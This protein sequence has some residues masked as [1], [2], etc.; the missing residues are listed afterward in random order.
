MVSEILFVA[1]I[2]Q[3]CCTLIGLLCMSLRITEAQDIERRGPEWS[4][5]IRFMNTFAGTMAILMAVTLVGA[6]ITNI[7]NI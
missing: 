5:R 2:A 7:Y 1:Y 4:R 3:M 6:I